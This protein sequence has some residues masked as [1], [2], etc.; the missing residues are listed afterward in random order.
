M[1][2]QEELLAAIN[3]IFREHSYSY[4]I[5]KY[6]NLY[7]WDTQISALFPG[8]H[9]INLSDHNYGTCFHYMIYLS[10]THV[11]FASKEFDQYIFANGFLDVVSLSISMLAS[12]ASISFGRYEENTEAKAS[13]L[14]NR[15]TKVTHLEAE[16]HQL[17]NKRLMDFLANEQITLLSEDLLNLTVPDISLELKEAPVTV[18]ECFFGF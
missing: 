4:I 7:Q 9:W 2:E 8:K 15:R 18:E 11:H 6:I 13:N 12:Y 1:S 10:P 14:E 5:G 16:T 17:I 3:N